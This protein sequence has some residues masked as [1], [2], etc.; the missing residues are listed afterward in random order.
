MDQQKA[1]GMETRGGERGRVITTLAFMVAILSATT[2][3]T[4]VLIG[5]EYDFDDGILEPFEPARAPVLLLAAAI[6]AA[7][8]VFSFKPWIRWPV[9][10]GFAVGSGWLLLKADFGAQHLIATLAL[11]AA[12]GVTA[13]LLGVPSSVGTYLARRTHHLERL[14]GPI[15]G[16]AAARRW[17]AAA[18]EWKGAG[19]L[20]RRERNHLGEHLMAWASTA[21]VPA[22]LQQ[23]I[24]PLVPVRGPGPVGRLLRRLRRRWPAADTD[25]GT[26]A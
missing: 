1:D 15:D 19:V 5:L 12:W 18:E 23:A 16:E 17:L 6:A 4:L 8:I 20:T 22:D 9:S 25:D 24:E 11:A 2:L 3:V 13:L 7:P 21:E 26:V 14:L 10:L